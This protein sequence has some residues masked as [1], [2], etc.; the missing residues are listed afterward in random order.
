MSEWRQTGWRT[1]HWEPWLAGLPAG[2]RA[3][4]LAEAVTWATACS[5]L[6]F[7]WKK[8]LIAATPGYDWDSSCSISLTV[9]V[10]ARS[11]MVVNL[12]SISCGGSPVYDQITLTTGISMLGKMSFGMLT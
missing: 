11:L 4:V 10:M 9:V 12:R 3:V 2:A 6:T 5:I 1:F 7:G 8:T